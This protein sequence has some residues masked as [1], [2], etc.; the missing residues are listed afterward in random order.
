M[1]EDFN[2]RDHVRQLRGR[3]GGN[4]EYLDVKYRIMWFRKDWPQGDIDTEHI[5]IDETSAVFRA[6]V[7]AKKDG[8]RMGMA[9]G[10]GSETQGDFNDFI[11]KAETK[12]IGRALN[13]LGYGT[14]FLPEDGD[15]IADAPVERGAVDSPIDF[16]SQRG[17]RLAGPS[18]PQGNSQ[19]ATPK[20]IKFIQAIAREAGLSEQGVREDVQGLFDCAVEDLSRKDASEYIERLHVLRSQDTAQTRPEPQDAIKP[21]PRTNHIPK[22][23]QASMLAGE[24]IVAEYRQKIA[25]AQSYDALYAIGEEMTSAGISDDGLKAAYWTRKAALTSDR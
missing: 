18:A 20:Q 25:A 13:A 22:D 2:P 4:A 15:R 5:R 10:Y 7:T 6:T 23:E 11:E 9:T 1:S 3:G 14:Q 19:T 12:A 8:N 21:A 16:A 17:R 24:Q